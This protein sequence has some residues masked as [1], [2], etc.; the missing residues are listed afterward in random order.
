[1]SDLA[2]DAGVSSMTR[3]TALKAVTAR[4][5]ARRFRDGPSGRRKA[6]PTENE[7]AGVLETL[8]RPD[9]GYAWEDQGIR[10]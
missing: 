9:G 2:A 3:R 6:A 10:I 1:M 8:A 4:G 5:S 7:C